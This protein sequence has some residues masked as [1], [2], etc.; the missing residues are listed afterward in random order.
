VIERRD[1][2][3]ILSVAVQIKR[4][5]HRRVL[6]APDGSD[7]L[8]SMDAQERPVPNAHLV[9][10]IGEAFAWRA[11]LLKTGGTI[12]ALAAQVNQSVANVKQRLHLTCLS[13]A[14]LRAVLTGTLP[15]R[16]TVHDLI[17]AG[18]RLDW[19]QQASALGLRSST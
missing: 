12:E 2:R 13:P 5:D 1:T 6:V 14:A 16:V 10:A 17:E 3:T 4:H 7:L 18:R 11:E 8:L 9:A 15:A 19:S